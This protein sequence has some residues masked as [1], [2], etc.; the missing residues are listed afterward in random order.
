MTTR[1]VQLAASRYGE[2]LE[3]LAAALDEEAKVRRQ[4]K[5]TVDTREYYEGEAKSHRHALETAL[6][7]TLKDGNLP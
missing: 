3:K 7:D 6:T 1:A 2:V 5:D 4:L